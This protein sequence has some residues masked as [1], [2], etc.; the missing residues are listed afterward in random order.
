M[1]VPYKGKP[2]GLLTDFG[3]ADH[4]V[5]VMKGV[6]AGIAPGAPVVDI[7]HEVQPYSIAQARFLLSQSWPWMPKGSVLVCVVDPGVGSSRRPIAVKSAGR[8]FVGPDNGLFSSLLE[9]PKCEVRLI[10]NT[11]FFAGPPSQT[12]HGRDIFAPVGAHLAAGIPFSRV[13]PRITDAMRTA[14]AAVVR[15]GRRFW[16]GEV[17]HVDRF[18]NLITNLPAEEFPN[19]RNRPFL[20][21]AGLEAIAS[22]VSSYAEAPEGEPVVLAASHGYLEIAVQQASAARRLGLAVGSPVEMEM[23]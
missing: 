18:G 17:V 6:I 4:F 10:E 9:E 19:L 3:L 7:S 23:P 20:L 2:I 14:G 8:I 13:G 22:F 16:Q 5:G 12:F 21:K 1:F 11:K 15:T